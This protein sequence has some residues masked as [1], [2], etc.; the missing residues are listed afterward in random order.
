MR[1]KLLCATTIAATALSTAAFAAPH[2]TG[3]FQ[4]YNAKHHTVT[5][6][7]VRVYHVAKDFKDA[8]L[9]RGEKVRATLVKDGKHYVVGSVA[10]EPVHHTVAKKKKK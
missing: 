3:V 5:L 6:T 7:T 9:K 2:V 10:A 4:S 8:G 1:F